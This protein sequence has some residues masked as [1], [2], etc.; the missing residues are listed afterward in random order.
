MPTKN[1]YLSVIIPCYNELQNLKRGVLKDV[2][3]YLKKQNFTWEVLISDDASTD[4]SSEY[5]EQFLIAKPQF[6][7]LRN[8]KGGK[9][10]AIKSGV[11]QAQ[12]KYV[13]FCDMDQSTPIVEFDKF[14][15]HLKKGDDVVIGS[16]GY[17]R[18]NFPLVRRIGS[19]IF[20]TFRRLLILPHLR[21]TQC[22][23]KCFSTAAAKNILDRM[24]IFKRQR[25]IGWRV[26]AWD[27]ELLFVADKLKYSIVEIPV[28]WRNEDTST[29]KQQ[30]FVQESV[31]MIK[32]IFRV[33]GNDIMGK[34]NGRLV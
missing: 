33:K 4:G 11:E 31:E 2:E 3:K 5:I 1:I 9:A 6:R 29:S 30:K 32:E 19:P 17:K 27:V 12:G 13:L 14:F 18:E 24:Q 34:Y 20:L 21:D 25:G 15:P 7:H 8:P 22:G 23:F 28:N 26:G 16:R 10:F